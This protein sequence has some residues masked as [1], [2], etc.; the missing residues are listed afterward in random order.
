MVNYSAGAPY[1]WV[2]VEVGVAYGSDTDKVVKALLDVARYHPE[3]LRDPEPFVRFQN[4]G[5]S[6]LDFR[7][8][9]ALTDPESRFS[10]VAQLRARIEKLFKRRRIEIAFPQVDVHLDPRVEES[11]TRLSSPPS[12]PPN[13][14]GGP[15]R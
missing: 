10:V 8:W 2:Y 9:G 14:D 5:F 4:F 3:I 12:P 11:L 1:L 6:S 13:K 15:D 7:L